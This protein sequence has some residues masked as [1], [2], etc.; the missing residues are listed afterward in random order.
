M[1][2]SVSTC[3]AELTAITNKRKEYT[4]AKD[5]IKTAKGTCNTDVNRY[6]K[7]ISKIKGDLLKMKK[8]NSFEGELAKQL[9]KE[10][11]N[12]K[13]DLDLAS[14]KADKLGT[15]ADSQISKIDTKLTELSTSET[16]W[17]GRLATATATAAVAAA[18]AAATSSK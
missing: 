5:K 10:V 17:N 18:A 1:T 13:K 16:T 9:T 14:K 15:A 11:S 12:F 3:K 7:T 2:Y 4:T 6:A 8:N